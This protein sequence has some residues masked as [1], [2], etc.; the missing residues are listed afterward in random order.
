VAV[1]TDT[2]SADAIVPDEA[3]KDRDPRRE[4]PKIKALSVTV[5]VP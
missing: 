5:I 4:S 2:V 1:V 3:G